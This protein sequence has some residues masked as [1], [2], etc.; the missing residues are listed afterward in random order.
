MILRGDNEVFQAGDSFPEPIGYVNQRDQRDEEQ[1]RDE[2]EEYIVRFQEILYLDVV[3][4][5]NPDVVIDIVFGVVIIFYSR[6][7]LKTYG[8]TR[9]LN[10][11]G[12][13]FGA[14]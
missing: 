14:L 4:E 6:A 13:Y 9:F 1:Q 10:G 8:C 2:I 7:S 3:G 12:L 11:C 5:C